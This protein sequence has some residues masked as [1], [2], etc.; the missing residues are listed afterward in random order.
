MAGGSFGRG[1]GGV[2]VGIG[3]DR[4]GAALD[5]GGELARGASLAG[6]TASGVATVEGTS[7][8]TAVGGG[9]ARGATASTLRARRR[10]P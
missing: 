4:F 3:L 6:G 2:P 9:G 7:G 5:R 8:A 10:E 1:G